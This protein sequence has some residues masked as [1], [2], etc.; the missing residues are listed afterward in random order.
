VKGLFML[1]EHEVAENIV[2]ICSEPDSFLIKL[3]HHVFDEEMYTKLVDEIKLYQLLLLDSRLMD[4]RVAGCLLELEQQLLNAIIA[5]ENR[6]SSP[7][8]TQQFQFAFNEI[9][10]LNACIFWSS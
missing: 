5:R 4:R 9:S 8:I 3:R 10:E 1:S 6:A 7:R 2:R